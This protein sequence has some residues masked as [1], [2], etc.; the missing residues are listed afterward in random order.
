MTSNLMILIFN[1]KINKLKKTLLLP[2][3][4]NIILIKNFNRDYVPTSNSQL[5]IF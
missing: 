5:V 2:K 3:F 1:K 4:N